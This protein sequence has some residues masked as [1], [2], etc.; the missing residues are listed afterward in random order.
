MKKIKKSAKL[1]NEDHNDEYD[2]IKYFL[3]N[4]QMT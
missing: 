4:G 3:K 2:D 1:V